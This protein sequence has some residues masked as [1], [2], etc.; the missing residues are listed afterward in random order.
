M[1]L[2]TQKNYLLRRN[3]A[4]QQLKGLST[5]KD[6]WS[7]WFIYCPVFI[8]TGRSDND[9]NLTLTLNHQY[10]DRCIN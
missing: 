7:Y 6:E 8:L 9:G 2:R 1:F 3:K 10:C 5:Q 4:N